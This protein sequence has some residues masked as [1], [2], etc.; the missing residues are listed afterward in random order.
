MSTLSEFGWYHL[1]LKGRNARCDTMIKPILII[2]TGNTIENLLARG[3]D[4]EDWFIRGSGYGKE[5]FVVKSLHKNEEL[6]AIDSIAGVIVTGSAAYVTDE[7]QWNFVGADYLR[8]ANES[9]IPILGVCYGHQLVAWAFDGEVAFSPSGREIGTASIRLTEAAREDPLFSDI[10][11]RF[12]AQIS[13]QQSV[14][15]LPLN[16]VRLATNEFAANQAYRI[17]DTTWGIQFH[18]EFSAEV[19]REYIMS[20]SEAISEEG[21]DS[22]VLLNAVKDTPHSG[23][24]LQKFCGLVFDDC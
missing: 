6:D 2:K 21:I 19:M 10:P 15:R 11:K 5:N 16:A 17:G 8:E 3:V 22:Q 20:R 14:M 24:I 12:N 1:F 18:P 23:A 13:H 4:F 7:E 9:L